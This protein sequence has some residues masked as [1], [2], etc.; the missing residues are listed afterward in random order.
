[1]PRDNPELLLVDDVPEMR[2]LLRTLLRTRGMT[3]VAEAPD[4][5]QAVELAARHQ[6]DVVVLDLGLPDLEG[7]DVL[8]EIRNHA[9]GCAVVVFS[10]THVM[11]SAA[12]ADRV[13][14][15]VSKD[16]DL[17]ILVDTLQHA[18]AKPVQLSTQVIPRQLRSVAVARAFTERTLSSWNMAAVL[19]DALIVVSELVTN[20][21]VH[22]G[23]AAEL[24][25]A[26]HK[27]SLRV[28]VVDHG[29][30]TPDPRALTPGQL[31]G[32]GLQIVTALSTAWGV[33]DLGEASKLVWAEL[34]TSP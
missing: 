12:I 8:T 20:A 23:T 10:G 18:A 33:S 16:Q 6:P 30:G 11:D 1:M 32:R 28:A 4:G 5:Q 2:T 31:G 13:E 9:P 14:G 21:V 27:R 15:F 26:R 29:P 24:R 17:S 7:Q 34:P 19:G 22:A 25:L 3:V